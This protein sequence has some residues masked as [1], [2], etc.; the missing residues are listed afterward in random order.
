MLAHEDIDP[1]RKLFPLHIRAC[2]VRGNTDCFG[3]AIPMWL[4]WGQASVDNC[5][6]QRLSLRRRW[7]SLWA[8]WHS[9]ATFLNLSRHSVLQFC[10]SLHRT[11]S[12][13]SWQHRVG[14]R[15]PACWVGAVG[16]RGSGRG[17]DSRTRTKSDTRPHPT[18]AHGKASRENFV[19]VQL[20]R[21]HHAN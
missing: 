13:A 16:S 14:G 6:C 21:Q 19:F 4:C 15:N 9:A 18:Q 1:V 20:G 5:R 12:C 7:L 17:S 2:C 11:I 10:V 3:K 8:D